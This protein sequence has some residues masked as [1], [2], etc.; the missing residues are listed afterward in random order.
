MDDTHDDTTDD[1]FRAGHGVLPDDADGVG[2][3]WRTLGGMGPAGER[4]I[5]ARLV[6]R[7]DS[8]GAVA[9]LFPDAATRDPDRE[10]DVEWLAGDAANGVAIRARRTDEYARLLDVARKRHSRIR[11]IPET[12]T[13]ARVTDGD[14]VREV[15]TFDVDTLQTD[16]AHLT[17]SHHPNRGTRPVAALEYTTRN[18]DDRPEAATVYRTDSRALDQQRIDVARA[19]ATSSET[20]EDGPPST[21][22]C[23]CCRVAV[24]LVRRVGHT[25]PLTFTCGLLGPSEIGRFDT[26]TF[27]AIVSRLDD[28]DTASSPRVICEQPEITLCP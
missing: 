10:I 24:G 21:I 17:V 2:G 18:A 22:T 3:L 23:D 28:P 20:D 12:T 15:V 16:T 9:A 5:A 26:L 27:A 4:G 6:L 11:P 25:A 8:A 14:R 19:L 1:W 13:A 7:A